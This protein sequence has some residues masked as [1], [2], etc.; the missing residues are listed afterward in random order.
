MPFTP[1]Q[2][3]IPDASMIKYP[4][5]WS[6]MPAAEKVQWVKNLTKPTPQKAA[7]QKDWLNA[8]QKNFPGKS[9]PK[10]AH[11][12]SIRNV[13]AP[14]SAAWP[15][16]KAALGASV[17][18]IL[19]LLAPIAAGAIGGAAIY[20]TKKKFDKEVDQYTR[21]SN[22]RHKELMSAIKAQRER[23]NNKNNQQPYE[24]SK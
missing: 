8:M 14:A 2:Y 4:S 13:A 12:E 21:E 15:G 11:E 19:S 7:A 6:N 5:N 3:N 23:K 17:S 1:P 10:V 18:P 9:M 22:Q 24:Q 16:V 20:R